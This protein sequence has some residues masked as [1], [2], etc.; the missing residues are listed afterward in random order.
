MHKPVN[1]EEIINAL[2]IKMEVRA[3]QNVWRKGE[4]LWCDEQGGCA[5]RGSEW[6]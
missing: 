2:E 4:D 6:C 5:S 3:H 1:L